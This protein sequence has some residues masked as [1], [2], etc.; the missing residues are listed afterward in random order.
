[1]VKQLLHSP[2]CGT[3]TGITLSPINKTEDRGLKKAN[4]KHAGKNMKQVYLI[5][6]QMYTRSAVVV[7]FPSAAMNHLCV[8]YKG[9]N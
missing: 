2:H 1:M 5:P 4:K 7:L 3:K 9:H 6:R 8:L